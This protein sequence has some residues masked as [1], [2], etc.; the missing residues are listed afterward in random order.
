MG[1]TG[2]SDIRDPTS[3]ISRSSSAEE[4]ETEGGGQGCTCVGGEEQKQDQLL[5]QVRLVG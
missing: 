3:P 4:E 1:L 2:S 5:Q